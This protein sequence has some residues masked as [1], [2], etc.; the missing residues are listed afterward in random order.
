MVFSISKAMKR[1]S[2]LVFVLFSLFFAH[3]CTNGKEA[4]SGESNAVE[5]TMADK[6]LL[7]KFERTACLGQCPA[8]RVTIMNDGS[9]TYEGM[10][11]APREGLY[12]STFSK[13]VVKEI[14]SEAE[15][16]GYWDF[17]EKYD[18]PVTDIPSTIYEIHHADQ[19]HRVVARVGTPAELKAYGKYLDKVIESVKWSSKAKDK[20]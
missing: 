3:A 17:K 18:A 7:L 5:E 4:S 8:F 9:A 15:R 1:T 20:K 11:F 10:T 13:E 6:S 12:K 2:P 16:I 19:Q 14:I